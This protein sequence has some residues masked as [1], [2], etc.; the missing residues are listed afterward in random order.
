MLL[1]VPADKCQSGRNA[2][3]AM[4]GWGFTCTNES[5][6]TTTFCGAALSIITRQQ[7]QQQRRV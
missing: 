3:R 4:D 2:N 5:S 7:Q 6:D 1:T